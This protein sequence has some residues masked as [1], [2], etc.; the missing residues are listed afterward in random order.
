MHKNNPATFTFRN[1]KMKILF[2]CNKNPS[3]HLF[4]S[5]YRHPLNV[6]PLGGIVGLGKKV[7]TNQ[8]LEPTLNL[9]ILHEFVYY[10]HITFWRFARLSLNSFTRQTLSSISA[11]GAE[12]LRCMFSRVYTFLVALRA[13]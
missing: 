2:A 3:E 1:R 9:H 12:N 6:A 5:M 13:P 8:R 11:S 4:T 7:S 10:S